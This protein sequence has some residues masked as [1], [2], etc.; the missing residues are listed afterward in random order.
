[1]GSKVTDPGHH[2]SSSSREDESGDNEDDEEEPDLSRMMA[3]RRGVVH[4]GTEAVIE[5]RI[6][7]NPPVTSIHWF[8]NQRPISNDF[9]LPVPGIRLS[10]NSTRL[11]IPSVT[12]RHEGMYKCSAV[13]IGGTGESADFKVIVLCKFPPAFMILICVSIFIHL[14]ESHCLSSSC[15]FSS[16][17]RIHPLSFIFFS[18]M[19]NVVGKNC[20][21]EYKS[22]GPF[23]TDILFSL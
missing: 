7:A 17:C 22:S 4:E 23:H 10:D 16:F 8:F 11:I 6:K 2:Q 1:M 20:C 13:N 9:P 12:K 15:C 5:C 19:L 14:L 3:R 18:V 21:R